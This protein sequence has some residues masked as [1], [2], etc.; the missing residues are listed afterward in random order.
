MNRTP[1]PSDLNDAEWLL[2]ESLLLRPKPG[3][4][5]IKYPRRE[6]VNVILC[7]LQGYR[8]WIFDLAV[9]PI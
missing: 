2:L 8:I 9:L 3:G 1:Y 4:G 6:I 7:I 5:P